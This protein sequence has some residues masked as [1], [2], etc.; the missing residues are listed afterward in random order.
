MPERSENRSPDKGKFSEAKSHPPL[1][2]QIDYFNA[3][4]FFRIKYK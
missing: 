1:K 2:R 4:M 3:R